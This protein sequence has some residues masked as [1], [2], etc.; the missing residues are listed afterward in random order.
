MR[1]IVRLDGWP[2]EIEGVDERR[3]WALMLRELEA[4]L[5]EKYPDW[6]PNMTIIVGSDD[7]EREA[8]Q[9]LAERWVAR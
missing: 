6:S 7:N 8:H 1:T 4:W 9:L 3:M 2:S 5:K